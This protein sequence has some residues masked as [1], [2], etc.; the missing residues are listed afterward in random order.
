MDLRL[1]ALLLGVLVSTVNE[2]ALTPA[3]PFLARDLGVGAAAAQGVVTAGLLGA[4]LAY[5]PFTLLAGRVGAGRVYRAGLLFH[6]LLAFLLFRASSLPAF[7]LLRFLQGVAAAGVVGLVPGLAA[8]AYPKRRGYALGLVASTVAAG[9][10]L[11]PALGGLLTGSLGWPYVFLLPLPLALLALSQSGRLPELP[12]QGGDLKRLLAS[13]G[14]LL[15]LLGTVLYFAHTLGTTLALAFFLA[16]EG[17]GPE[18]VGSL[19]LL[20]PL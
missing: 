6:A 2:S 13:K 18:T 7:Y 12:P 15:A 19:L 8:A 17:L 20:S 4:A 5:L 16:E 11:G 14:F 3:L 9:T 10:L 1:L